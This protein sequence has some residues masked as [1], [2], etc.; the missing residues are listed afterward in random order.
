MQD[1]VIMFHGS[2]WRRCMQC[3]TFIFT[4]MYTV[5]V[6]PGPYKCPVKS[7]L[8]DADAC[9]DIVPHTFLD[10]N[11]S[12]GWNKKSRTL[13][14]LSLNFTATVPF[15]VEYLPRGCARARY[16]RHLG[17]SYS[18]RPRL[19]YGLKGRPSRKHCGKV[20][21]GTCRYT[22]RNIRFFCR[23]TLRNTS[24]IHHSRDGVCEN[25][26]LRPSPGMRNLFNRHRS[27]HFARVNKRCRLNMRPPAP[28]AKELVGCCTTL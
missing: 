3:H 11:N 24:I 10:T 12:E 13:H 22:L 1:G 25:L 27:P 23:Y 6:T 8:H 26:I 20:R 19:P 14:C 16:T 21:E 7:H 5:F 4:C 28:L 9:T 2:R 18:T 15:C 17:V